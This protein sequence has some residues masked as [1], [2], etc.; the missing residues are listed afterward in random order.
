M[1]NRRAHCI[2]FTCF[3]Y[4]IK[5]KQQALWSFNRNVKFVSV[6]CALSH[7]SALIRSF[8]LHHP[9]PPCNDMKPRKLR[10]IYFGSADLQCSCSLEFIFIIAKYSIYWFSINY[11]RQYHYYLSMYVFC[12]YSIFFY[13]SRILTNAQL[14]E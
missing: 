6:L 11:K 3:F 5:L 9:F 4:L 2:P 12:I 7:R 14:V 10:G 1:K 8:F 13:I